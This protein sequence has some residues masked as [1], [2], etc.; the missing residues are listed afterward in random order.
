MRKA[1]RNEVAA[2]GR[3]DGFLDSD[4]RYHSQYSTFE[5]DHGKSL[6]RFLKVLASALLRVLFGS[7]LKCCIEKFSNVCGSSGTGVPSI[8]IAKSKFV[9]I[10]SE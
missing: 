7:E 8:S 10:L 3:I 5:K 9:P 4:R 2:G 1:I 6:S